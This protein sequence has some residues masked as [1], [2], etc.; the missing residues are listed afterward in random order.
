MP[1]T[2]SLVIAT[3][4]RAH[5]LPRCLLL[6][7]EQTRP[8]IQIVVVDAS[9][10]FETCRQQVLSEIAPTFPNISWEYVAAER[11]SSASQRNQGVRLATGDV[12]FLIDDDSLMYPDCAEEAMKIYEADTENK[13]GGIAL[14]H[15]P[16]PPEKA[17]DRAEANKPATP[18]P[19]SFLRKLK[20]NLHRPFRAEST[21]LP[22]D[23]RYP[24]HKLPDSVQGMAITPIRM[25]GGCFMTLRRE[26]AIREPFE[27]CLER[28]AAAEDLD[29]SYR[30]SRH[31]AL[32][33]AFR[34]RIHH[35]AASGGRV[36][37]FSAIALGALNFAVLHRL[38][39]TNLDR[40]K[41]LY[42]RI[43]WKRFSLTLSADIVKRR[44]NLPTSR[45]I[46][47]SI[48]KLDHIFAMPKEELR[49]WYPQ[50]QRE[51]IEAHSSK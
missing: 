24:D 7:A 26:M 27:V 51:L 29:E 50:F 31:A 33:R 19:N 11:A 44:W 49:A 30:V 2:W 1:L 25:I 21:H 39:S 45:A 32:V 5:I 38:N 47:F 18:S 6:A 15:V 8:P 40:S 36:S 12:L 48:R 35:V 20:Y 43:L 13:I 41:R 4:K 10:D 34:A 16:Q 17:R 9:P 28:Y 22:Y 37:R 42:R 14:V 23:D 3:Y 46:L